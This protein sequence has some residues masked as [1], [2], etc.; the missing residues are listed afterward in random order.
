[1]TKA[2]TVEQVRSRLAEFIAAHGRATTLKRLGCKDAHLRHMLNGTR[3]PSEAALALL[4]LAPAYAPTPTSP[5]PE[6]D[7]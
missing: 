6:R 5:S 1:M 3:N 4:N 7:R 2:Y